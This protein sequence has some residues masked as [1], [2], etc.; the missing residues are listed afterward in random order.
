MFLEH[1]LQLQDQRF[2]SIAHLYFLC[3]CPSGPKKKEMIP[4]SLGL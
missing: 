1:I 4:L 3:I 2:S